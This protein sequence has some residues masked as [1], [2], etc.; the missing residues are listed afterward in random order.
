[1]YAYVYVYT[2]CNPGIRLINFEGTMLKGF[3]GIFRA[4]NTSLDFGW[5]SSRDKKPHLKNVF[6]EPILVVDRA[7]DYY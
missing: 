6:L 3:F 4:Q 1:M 7:T 5:I 2:I